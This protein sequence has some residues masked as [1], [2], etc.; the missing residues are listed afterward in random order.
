MESIVEPVPN[1]GAAIEA[2]PRAYK[3]YMTRE[4]SCH[5][6][7]WMTSDLGL[8]LHTYQCTDSGIELVLRVIQRNAEG[9]TYFTPR[10]NLLSVAITKPRRGTRATDVNIELMNNV[11]V[12]IA[13]S[14]GLPFRDSS[15]QCSDTY[16]FVFFPYSYTL[17][18]DYFQLTRAGAAIMLYYTGGTNFRRQ[19]SPIFGIDKYGL[20]SFAPIERW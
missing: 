14:L 9:F 7:L 6:W 5:S 15:I 11:D 4:L 18:P 19:P 12:S 1:P 16:F 3:Q 20:S 10:C 13:G 8:G 17:L 2:D